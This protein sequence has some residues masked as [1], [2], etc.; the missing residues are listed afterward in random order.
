MRHP[1]GTRLLIR[2]GSATNPLTPLLITPYNRGKP[3]YPLISPVKLLTARFVVRVH[4]GEPAF[5][6]SVIDIRGDWGGGGGYV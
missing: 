3:Q 2:G 5:F 4:I 6:H 1:E